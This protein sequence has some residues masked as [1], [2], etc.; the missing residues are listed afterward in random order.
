MIE[1][2]KAI[3]SIKSSDKS[4]KKKAREVIEQ[5]AMPHWALG[6]LLDCACE[7][8]AITGE[9]KPKFDKRLMVVMAGDHGVVAEGVSPYP[10]S[11][12]AAMVLTMLHGGAGINVLAK[13]AQADVKLVDMGVISD[14][15]TNT[16]EDFLSIKKIARGTANMME[17]P[18]MSREHAIKSIETGIECAK[19]WNDYD[20]YGVGEMGIGNT[21]SASAII[22]VLTGKEVFEVT[23]RGTGLDD[24]GLEKKIQIIE[25]AIKKNS[26]NSEDAVDV[27]SKLGGFEIGGMAGFYIGCAVN[28]KPVLIDGLISTSAAL[29]ANSIEPKVADYMLA[30]HKSVE[31]GHIYSLKHLEKEPFFDL[32]LRLGE[33]TGAALAMPMVANSVAIMNE[34]M[35]LEQ[36]ISLIQ[37]S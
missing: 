36:A 30:S 2:D 8:A 3:A 19:Q 17:G 14:I 4:M 28:K 12:T 25:K 37:P 11:V 16:N 9:L 1:L 23:G 7:C 20:L 35:S 18:A 22:S 13:Q 10:Q 6:K 29:I 26:P 31:P 21:T 24:K 34:M 32:N 5:L 27:L 15:N 33:G